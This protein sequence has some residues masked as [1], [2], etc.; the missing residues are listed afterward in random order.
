MNTL[1]P[2][3]SDPVTPAPST[4]KWAAVASFL[5]A[6]A[7]IV[8]PFVYLTG[9]LKSAFGPFTYSLAD[10]LY[11][12][13]WAASLV[14]VVFALREQM[15]DFA[16]R[17]MTLA[18]LVAVFA[19]GAMLLVAMIRSANRQYYLLHPDL[20]YETVL[21]VWTTLV[22]GVTSTGWHLLGW[23]LLLTGSAGWTSRRLPRALCFLSCVIGIAALFVYLFP[24]LEGFVVLFG[25]AWSLWQG[26]LFW[27][28][29]RVKPLASEII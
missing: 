11:G 8:A 14:M 20:T 12:P 17:R 7:F 22:T 28:G 10:F 23:V 16:P 1:P 13:V 3:E 21:V 29:V 26:I 5:L 9:E 6:V 18:L 24:E 4:R 2:V 27:R 25:V 15:A 19:A